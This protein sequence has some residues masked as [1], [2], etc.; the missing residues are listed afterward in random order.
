MTLEP[1]EIEAWRAHIDKYAR[2]PQCGG[3]GELEGTMDTQDPP[4]DGDP[5]LLREL[6]VCPGCGHRWWEGW[7][8]HGQMELPT[9]QEQPKCRSEK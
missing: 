5:M 2:C 7:A 4:Q 6:V 3:D 8:Y 1:E 9:E